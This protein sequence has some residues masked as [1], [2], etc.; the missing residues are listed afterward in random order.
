M[1]VDD[2]LSSL[3]ALEQHFEDLNVTIKKKTSA[4]DALEELLKEKV[5]CIVVDYAMPDMNG[6][7]FMKIV[8]GDPELKHIPILLVT[9]KVFSSN[10]AVQALQIGAYDYMTK[11]VNICI[12][13]SKIELMVN[14]AVSQQNFEYLFSLCRKT[15]TDQQMADLVEPLSGFNQ[16]LME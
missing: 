3:I 15:L 6:M 13:K 4:S 2:Q 10:Q 8:K 16:D 9:G 7:E 12:I 14:Y 11:P 5:H 1:L